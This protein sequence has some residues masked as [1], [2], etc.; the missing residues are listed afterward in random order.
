ME[1]VLD[2]MTE[3][4]RRVPS[5]ELRHAFQNEFLSSCSQLSRSV[6]KR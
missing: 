1:A 3:L 6:L 2:A 4:M 5:V